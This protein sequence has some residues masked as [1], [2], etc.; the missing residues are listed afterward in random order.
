[1]MPLKEKEVLEFQ[2]LFKEEF[3]EDIDYK[4]AEKY[5]SDLL[6]FMVLFKNMIKY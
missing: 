6:E 1:M 2:K 5:C 3:N 4:T